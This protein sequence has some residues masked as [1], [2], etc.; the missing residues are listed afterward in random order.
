MVNFYTETGLYHALTTY[1]RRIMMG[2]GMD[3]NWMKEAIPY[4]SDTLKQ[5]ALWSETS[6][7]E[8]ESGVVVYNKRKPSSFFGLLNICSSIHLKLTRGNLN[9]N[10]MQDHIQWIFWGDKET[11]WMGFEFLTL[12]YAFDKH[13]GSSVGYSNS[14]G[15]VCG[16]L[17]HADETG[18]LIWFN[19]GLTIDK[20][21]SNK[22]ALM[23]F[24][25]YTVDSSFKD[26]GE[27]S[28]NDDLYRTCWKSAMP[29]SQIKKLSTEEL[30]LLKT[31]SD[32]YLDSFNGTL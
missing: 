21:P 29:K 2:R 26:P 10:P 17:A 5:T 19:G 7:N 12:P 25:Y 27:W 14:P 13:Y 1:T 16:S 8:A 9:R 18:K 11:H 22:K 32:M 20:K 28:W 15:V 3:F 6:K 4:A 23:D 24:E 31:F 30:K